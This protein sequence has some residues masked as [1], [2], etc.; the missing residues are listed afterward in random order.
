MVADHGVGPLVGKKPR[1][2]ALD[3]VG[4]LRVLGAAV[5]EGDDHVGTGLAGQGHVLLD[6]RLAQHADRPRR[7]VGQ[8]DAVGRRGVTQDGDAPAVLLDD[9]DALVVGLVVV[10]ARDRDLRVVYAPV[11]ELRLNAGQ[12]LVHRVV[13]RVDGH[14]EAGGD[15]CVDDLLRPVERRETLELERFASEDGLLFDHGD[16]SRLDIGLDVRKQVVVVA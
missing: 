5:R 13:V 10:D 9:S 16:V 1:P 14:V 12:A 6:A 2:V 15:L 11:R 8:R 4:L 7:A 3:A